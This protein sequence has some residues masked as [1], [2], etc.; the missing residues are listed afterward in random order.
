MESATKALG[1]P[2]EG[3]VPD[4]PGSVSCSG[5]RDAGACQ[6]GGGRGGQVGAPRE[7][8]GV[9]ASGV[10]SVGAERLILCVCVCVYF[11]IY[12]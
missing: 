10:T 11:I 12:I 1:P 2:E 5:L 7:E 8:K 3:G 9:K 4:P 6:A